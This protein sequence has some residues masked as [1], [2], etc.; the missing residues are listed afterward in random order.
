MLATEEQHSPVVGSDV[1]SAIPSTVFP[2]AFTK[3][4]HRSM[5]DAKLLWM[6]AFSLDQSSPLKLL[7]DRSQSIASGM[8]K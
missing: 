7:I 8:Q 3:L 6:T 5:S 4:I 1:W 2:C